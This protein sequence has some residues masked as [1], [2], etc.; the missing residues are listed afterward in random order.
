MKMNKLSFFIL[1]LFLVPLVNAGV[2]Y[3]APMSLTPGEKGDFHFAVDAALFDDDLKCVIE[4]DFRTLLEINFH[5]EELS[6]DAGK[7]IFVEGDVVVPKDIEEGYYEE[8]FCVSCERVTE[9]SGVSTRPRYCDIPVRVTVVKEPF[10][11]SFILV[12]IL[13]VLL[14][15]AFI[16]LKRRRKISRKTPKHI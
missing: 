14:I 9:T 7:R 11:F 4:F 10:G 16:F 13:V 6:I 5:E 1:L 2:S 3:P 12:I 8:S 15:L